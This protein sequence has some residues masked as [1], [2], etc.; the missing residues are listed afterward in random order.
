MSV[1]WANTC[2][3]CSSSLSSFRFSPCTLSS[4]CCFCS[5]LVCRW[6]ICCSYSSCKLLSSSRLSLALYFSSSVWSCMFLRYLLSCSRSMLCCPKKVTN[7]M[8]LAL[9]L[10][11][12]ILGQAIGARLC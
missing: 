10:F 8:T 5:T 9:L 3:S 11:L 2:H 4:S 7:T 12:L 6:E 1:S